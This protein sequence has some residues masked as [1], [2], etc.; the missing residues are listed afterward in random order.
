[1]YDI[2]ELVSNLMVTG[3]RVLCAVAVVALG[4]V[5]LDRR[6]RPRVVRAVRKVEKDRA[7]RAA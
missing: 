3:W 2:V 1:M 5:I 6:D 7:R 4:L